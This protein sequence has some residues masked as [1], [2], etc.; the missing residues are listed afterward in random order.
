MD[1]FDYAKHVAHRELYDTV[2]YRYKL[3]V[4]EFKEKRKEEEEK[5]RKLK[6]EKDRAEAKKKAELE[7]QK[8][9]QEMNKQRLCQVQ[10]AYKK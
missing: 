10:N 8:S 3:M 6:E 2:R 5:E 1:E 7:A 4:D 9:Q